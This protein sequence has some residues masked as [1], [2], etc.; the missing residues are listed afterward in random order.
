MGSW[1]IGCGRQ[2]QTQATRGIPKELFAP[3]FSVHSVYSSENGRANKE[4]LKHVTI[5]ALV[6]MVPTA[7]ASGLSDM[8]LA[9]WHKR[10][11]PGCGAY[12]KFH[13]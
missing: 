12:L 9:D 5:K 11:R 7:Q 2:G 8:T 13:E 10:H 4:S 1:A 6:R 3:K